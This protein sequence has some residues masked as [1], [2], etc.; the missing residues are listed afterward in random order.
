MYVSN[1]LYQKHFALHCQYPTC[2]DD[3]V[4]QRF[5]TVIFYDF[6]GFHHNV[7]QH[8]VEHIAFCS[9]ELQ[10]SPTTGQPLYLS[11]LQSRGIYTRGYWFWLGAA[12]LLGYTIL[13]NVLATIALQYLN[14]KCK[15]SCCFDRKFSQPPT[16]F[17]ACDSFELQRF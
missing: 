8:V 14:R 16:C 13:F 11:I 9:L 12:V 7:R 3:I 1:F 6:H 5:L 2:E 10:P 17:H 4:L 15:I